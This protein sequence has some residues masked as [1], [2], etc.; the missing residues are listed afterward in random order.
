[1]RLQDQSFN[2][3]LAVTA[4]TAA[5]SS[6]EAIKTDAH[7][8]GEIIKA[9]QRDPAVKPDDLFR[10]EWMY[11]PILD[12]AYGA[13]P[14]Q[15]ERRLATDPAFFCEVIRLVFRSQNETEPVEPSEAGQKIAT[16]AYRLR[17]ALAVARRLAEE[18]HFA[19]DHLFTIDPF[20]APDVQAP[21]GVPTT[22]FYQRRSWW[23]QGPEVEGAIANIFVPDAFHVDIT[24]KEL[25]KTTIERTIVESRGMGQPLGGRY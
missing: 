21:P 17:A 8:L 20:E 22:N 13:S 16:N 7:E 6:Q 10:V 12:H 19:P 2:G 11:L 25:V 14:V 3:A 5:A 24:Q 15:L 1:M 4:L 18:C 9:L 23:F